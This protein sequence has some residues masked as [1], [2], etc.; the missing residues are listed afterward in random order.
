VSRST[1]D[2]LIVGAGAAGGVVAKELATAEFHVVV[3]EQGPWL[4]EQDFQH[5][6]VWANQRR[7]RGRA[8]RARGQR[9]SRR[10]CL[11]HHPRLLRAGSGTWPRGRRHRPLHRQLVDGSSFVTGGRGQPTCT[12]QVL[13]YRASTET[14]RLAWEG[15]LGW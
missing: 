10:P 12:I 14:T 7:V 1:A 15:A 8:V 3:L 11:A 5:D 4:H 13:A 9:V 2:F 6:E